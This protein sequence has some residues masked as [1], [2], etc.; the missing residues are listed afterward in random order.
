MA[1]PQVLR[2]ALANLIDNA[3]E[4]MVESLLRVLSI[5]LRWERA[6]VADIVVS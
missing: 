6:G 4:A 3:A 5:E 1:D 2:R